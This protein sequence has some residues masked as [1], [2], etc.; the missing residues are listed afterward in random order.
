MN[1]T[2]QYVT[3]IEQPPSLF[4]H[5]Q[6]TS[7]SSKTLHD[8]QTSR[9]FKYSLRPSTLRDHKKL[10]QPIPFN[11]LT[12]TVLSSNTLNDVQTSR[13]SKYSLHHRKRRDCKNLVQ[14]TALKVFYNIIYLLINVYTLV[15]F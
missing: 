13:S 12:H 5:L 10:D 9:S 14:P 7:P 15:L 2:E 6:Y 8:I 4:N 1:H 3:E 11:D